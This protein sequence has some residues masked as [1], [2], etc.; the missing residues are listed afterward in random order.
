MHT[1]IHIINVQI[2]I[3]KPVDQ[4]INYSSHAPIDSRT[5]DIVRPI[6]IASDDPTKQ[7]I[8]RAVVPI[9]QK[10]VVPMNCLIK[11]VNTLLN[12]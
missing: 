1:Y 4:K 7:R 12:M 2:E 8:E 3:A 6:D 5:N 11:K 10:T 9:N